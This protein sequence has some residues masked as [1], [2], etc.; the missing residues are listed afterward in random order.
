[1]VTIF[2]DAEQ[3]GVGGVSYGK[4]FHAVTEQGRFSLAIRPEYCAGNTMVEVAPDCTFITAVELPEI[5]IS[6]V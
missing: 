2:P 5:V 6:M 4:V 1:M 3:D